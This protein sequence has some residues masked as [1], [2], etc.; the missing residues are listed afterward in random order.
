MKNQSELQIDQE[1]LDLSNRCNQH[2][3]CNNE[4]WKTCGN[5]NE[6]ISNMILHIDEVYDDNKMMLCNYHLPFGGE[7]YCTCPARKYI[8]NKFNV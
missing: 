6:I 8:Y 1:S 4:K 3:I 2:H 7:H 5:V